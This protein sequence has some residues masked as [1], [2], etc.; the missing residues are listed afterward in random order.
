MPEDTLVFGDIHV[1]E[2]MR[3]LEREYVK[4]VP[5]VHEVYAIYDNRFIEH[6]IDDIQY[7][8]S[9]RMITEDE[10][11]S[12]KGELLELVDYLEDVALKGYYP[13]SGNKLFFYLSHTWLETEYFLCESKY[14]TLSMVKILEL[15][16]ISSWDKKVFDRCMN[17]VQFTKRSSVLLSA[18]N[19]LQI[20]EFFEKQR[21]I[22]ASLK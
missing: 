1:P 16:S 6:L 18:S 10:V 8:R 11:V 5:D 3:K 13:V 20:I 12:L 9:V 2:R 21:N 7:F 19:N 4:R 15:G 14:L 22:I 17:M